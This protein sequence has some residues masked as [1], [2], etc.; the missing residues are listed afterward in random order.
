[1]ILLCAWLAIS[2]RAMP[3]G[4]PSKYPSYHANIAKPFEGRASRTGHVFCHPIGV[5]GNHWLLR[6]AVFATAVSED[7]A[8]DAQRGQYG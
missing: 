1:M 3:S 4:R 5:R 8:Q 2:A 6:A 7:L